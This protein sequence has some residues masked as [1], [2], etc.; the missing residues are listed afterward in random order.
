MGQAHREGSVDNNCHRILV[1]LDEQRR[2]C[3][4]ATTCRLTETQLITLVA[5]PASE[6][7]KP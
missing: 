7:H 3:A 1:W 2:S 6:L 5:D 4:T